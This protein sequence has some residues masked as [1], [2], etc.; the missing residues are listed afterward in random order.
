M[1]G[2]HLVERETETVKTQMGTP[3]LLLS[4]AADPQ[5]RP[6]TYVCFP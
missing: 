4:H 2:L 5:D 1:S 6:G 3:T